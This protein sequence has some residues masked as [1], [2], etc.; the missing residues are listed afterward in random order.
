MSNAVNARKKMVESNGVRVGEKSKKNAGGKSKGWAYF[1]WLFGGIFGAHHVYLERDDHA[2]VWFCTLGGYFGI[3]WLRD[4][5]KIPTYVA[6][7]NDQP[8]YIEW[9]KLQVRSNKKVIQTFKMH[10]NYCLK[11]MR[12]L[13]SISTMAMAIKYTKKI[14]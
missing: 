4:L 5:F 1:W 7:A 14:K 6:D 10:P 11:I 13:Q 9:F 8:Q 12:I 3:G 2:F